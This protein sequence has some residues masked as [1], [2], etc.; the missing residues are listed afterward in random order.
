MSQVGFIWLY[1]CH[2]IP[3]WYI[4]S[5]LFRKVVVIGCKSTS[6]SF[7]LQSWD[8]YL[9][10]DFLLLFILSKIDW[11]WCP[12]SISQ[13]TIFECS[14]WFL[15]TIRSWVTSGEWWVCRVEYKHQS[16]EMLWRSYIEWVK[17]QWFVWCYHWVVDSLPWTL[18]WILFWT[19]FSHCDPLVRSLSSIRDLNCSQISSKF[20]KCRI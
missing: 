8:S 2:S 18:S 11:C 12:V 17:S 13:I 9:L 10:P 4:M 15:N 20:E 6:R 19:L 5:F 14:F 3:S 16:V 1:N 7:L